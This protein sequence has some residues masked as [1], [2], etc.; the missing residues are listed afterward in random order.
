MDSDDK[1]LILTELKSKH[2]G[3]EV[4]IPVCIPMINHKTGYSLKAYFFLGNIP[5]TVFAAIKRDP[6]NKEDAAI[7]SGYYGPKWKQYLT[8]SNLKLNKLNEKF[9]IF[10]GSE[11]LPINFKEFDFD[12]NEGPTKLIKKSDNKINFNYS[13]SPASI[14]LFQ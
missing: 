3:H 11:D 12:A 6:W 10:G 14:L 4:I 7:I 9:S 1:P 5:K 2:S 13:F 8:A